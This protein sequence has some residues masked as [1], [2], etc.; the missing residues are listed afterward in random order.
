MS[1]GIPKELKN[2]IFEVLKELATRQPGTP[3]SLRNQFVRERGNRTGN[4]DLAVHAVLHLTDI[5]VLDP[6]LN[7]FRIT[8][9][10]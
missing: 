9:S 10:G 5:G 3:P 1:K 7:G 6:D 2:E 4:E 8:A